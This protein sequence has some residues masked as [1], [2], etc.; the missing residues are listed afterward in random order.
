[1]FHN[2]PQPVLDRMKQLEAI[3]AA[4]RRDGT[5]HAERLRQIPPETGRFIA[6]TAAN[7]PP[8]RWLEVGTSAGYSTLWLSL[9]GRATGRFIITFEALPNK[10]ALATETFGQAAVA[11]LITLVY[12]DAR[13]H[14]AQSHDVAFAFID[15]EKELYADCY[16]LIVPNLVSGGVILMDNAIS[17]Q[18]ELAPLMERIYADER[19]DAVLVPIGQ[20]VFMCRKI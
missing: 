14:L 3:D 2:I 20:G 12:G 16:D 8:G 9:A 4:D 15:T 18:Q 10:M 11:D 17:H 6:L 1:M 5:S 13:D 7:T 19:V